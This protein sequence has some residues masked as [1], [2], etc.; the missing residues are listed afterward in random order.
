M[1]HIRNLKNKHS[2]GLCNILM[3]LVNIYVI[4]LFDAGEVNYDNVVIGYESPRFISFI[5]DMWVLPRIDLV[6]THRDSARFPTLLTWKMYSRR[7]SF[8]FRVS[9][10]FNLNKTHKNVPF[11]NV[12]H[13]GIFHFGKKWD[14]RCFLVTYASGIRP[15]SASVSTLC[16]SSL[17]PPHGIISY[18]TCMLV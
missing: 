12:L 8:L 4:L 15:V 13:L 1:R 10:D 9:I 3:I 7:R 11:R 14:F 2:H 6:L 18:C 16:T 17:K 5:S